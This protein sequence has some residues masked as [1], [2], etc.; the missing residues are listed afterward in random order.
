LALARIRLKYVNSYFDRHGVERHY[1]RKRGMK[2]GIRLNGIPGSEEFMAVYAQALAGLP[3]AEKTEIG[4]KRTLPGSVDALA[5]S[6]YRSE[7]WLNL[8]EGTRRYRRPI[9]ERWRNRHGAKRVALLRREHIMKMLA[10]IDKILAKRRWLAAILPLLRHA[11]PVMV[12][13]DLTVGIA[14]PKIKIKGHHSWTDAEIAQ[15]RAYWPCG[16]QQRLALEFAKPFHGVARLCA[17]GRN[18]FTRREM[19]SRGYTSPAPTARKM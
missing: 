6:Y 7:N 16:T 11:T 5:I 8:A 12:K 2:E 14:M 4:A 13:E 10:E 17:W 19:A 1:F 18:M 15:Y 3:D 9:I